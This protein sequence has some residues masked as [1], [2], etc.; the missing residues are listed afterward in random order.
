MATVTV[1]ARDEAGHTVT[2]TAQI[3]VRRTSTALFGSSRV[4]DLPSFVEHVGATRVYSATSWGK[5]E[6]VAALDRGCRAFVISTKTVDPASLRAFLRGKPSDVTVYLTY[7]HEHEDNLRDGSL[8]LAQYE[9]GS[10][11]VA[12]VAHEFEGVLYGPIHN[13]N[14]KNAA[15]KWVVGEWVD[16]S[17]TSIYDFWGTDIYCPDNQDPADRFAPIIAKARALGL[18]LVI[19]ETGA[20]NG[21]GQAA[22]AAKARAWVEQHDAVACY[23]HSQ[24]SSADTNWRLTDDAA[25]V[26]FGI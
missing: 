20:P 10:R 7:W 16:V 1:T 5:A 3:A 24:K 14:N 11:T 21:P 8:T 26:W 22:W 4:A 23:W 6:I 9:A 15:G 17:D 25:R 18:P 12:D 13:G 19:G 2:R